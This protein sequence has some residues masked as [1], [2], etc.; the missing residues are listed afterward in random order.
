MQN[1][2]TRKNQKDK[3]KMRKRAINAKLVIQISK[4]YANQN[5]NE[6][7]DNRIIQRSERDFESTDSYQ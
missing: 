2:N 3:I 7:N 6:G 4:K 1:E 5:Y